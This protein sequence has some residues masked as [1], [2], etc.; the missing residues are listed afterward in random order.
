[1]KTTITSALAAIALVAGFS[2]GQAQAH[3]LIGTLPNS[4][5]PYAIPHTHPG[6]GYSVQ[7]AS[8]CPR[9][10]VR[11]TFRSKVSLVCPDR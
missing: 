5:V 9:T 10:V 8:E 6:G 11:H 7:S 1:M 4:G 2:T 3:T